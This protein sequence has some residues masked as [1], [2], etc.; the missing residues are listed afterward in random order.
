MSEPSPATLASVNTTSSAVNGVPSW[1]V[2]PLRSSNRHTVGEVCFQDVAKAG[3][4][5]RS[6]PRPTSGS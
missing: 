5:A 3:A 1:K 6:L 4:S 2:T